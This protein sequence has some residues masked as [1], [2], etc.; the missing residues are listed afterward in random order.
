MFSWRVPPA[1]FTLSSFFFQFPIFLYVYFPFL[2]T[3]FVRAGSLPFTAD[4]VGGGCSPDHTA[5]CGIS[6]QLSGVQSR[7]I[8]LWRLFG[9]ADQRGPYVRAC[10]VGILPDAVRR[11]DREEASNDSND[12][13]SRQQR[14]VRRRERHKR[15]SKRDPQGNQ[16]CLHSLSLSLSLSL[17]CCRPYYSPWRPVVVTVRPSATAAL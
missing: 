3:A 15:K 6:V 14:R 5:I 16:L 1:R 17:F 7:H 10:A 12:R 2:D 13:P 8:G 4:A 9:A 11:R